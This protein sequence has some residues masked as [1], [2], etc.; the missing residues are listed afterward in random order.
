MAFSPPGPA[1]L[2][3]EGAPALRTLL[4]IRGGT[5]SSSAAWLMGTSSRKGTA[6]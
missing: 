5:S 6:L 1:P 4:A 2:E 3:A